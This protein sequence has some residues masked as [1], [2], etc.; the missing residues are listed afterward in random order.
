MEN[1]EL[2]QVLEQIENKIIECQPLADKR[3]KFINTLTPIKSKLKAVKI[4]DKYQDIYKSLVKKGQELEKLIKVTANP[5]ELSGKINYY[6]NYLTAAYGDFTGQTYKITKFYRVFLLCSILFLILSPQFLT[7][8]FSIIFII[9]IFMAMKGIKQRVKTG[10]L[11]SMLLV[12]ASLMTG[13]M[14]IR[15]GIFVLQNFDI[16]VSQIVNTYSINL[17]LAQGITVIFPILGVLITII[18]VYLFMVG[19]R[20]KTLF[21]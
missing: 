20:V 9:P 8:I 13:V 3:D 19:Q 14:W 5:K 11:L 4:E 18:A 12:P 17:Q 10:F 15:Y 1:N 2:I 21:V 16:A 7:P 6:I